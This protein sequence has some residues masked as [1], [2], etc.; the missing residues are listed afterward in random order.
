MDSLNRLNLV[1]RVTYYIGWLSL[2]IGGLVHANLGKT[3]FQA[4]SLSQ[5]NLFEVAAISFLIC[6]ASALRALTYAK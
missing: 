2:V 6:T 1:A 3:L 4:I 5:R